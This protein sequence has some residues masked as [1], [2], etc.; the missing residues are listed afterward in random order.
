MDF[1]SGLASFTDTPQQKLVNECTSDLLI[2]MDLKISL[3]I[4]DNI[5]IAPDGG[6]EYLKAI[7]KR[8]MHKSQKVSL[9]AL[10]LLETC[11]KNCHEQFHAQVANREFLNSLLKLSSATEFVAVKEKVLEL[12]ASWAKA[13]AHGGRLGLFAT[14]Y[15]ELTQKGVRFPAELPNQAPVLTPQ[16][17]VPLSRTS[18]ETSAQ[19]NAPVTPVRAPSTGSSTAVPPTSTTTETSAVQT[20]AASMPPAALPA[21]DENA[22]FEK[23]KQDLGVV[24]NYI[25]L[26]R[27]M[28]AAA[29]QEESPEEESPAE[30]VQRVTT[31]L[32]QNLTL[33][34]LVNTLMAIRNRLTLIL[35][36]VEKE[37][38]LTLT[39]LM[40]EEVNAALQWH[41]RKEEGKD[42]KPADFVVP[43]V[44][45]P[46]TQETPSS[47]SRPK[48]NGDKDAKQGSD[49]KEKQE[50]PTKKKSAEETKETQTK[51]SQPPPE[52]DPFADLFRDDD[53]GAPLDLS[54]PDPDQPSS[55]SSSSSSS[56][57]PSAVTSSS[58]SPPVPG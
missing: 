12:I 8:I 58:S 20:T 27:E 51:P 11:M 18:R 17:S 35:V 2:E 31:K 36:E 22:Y 44:L 21:Y 34:S 13:F 3:D 50:K 38:M 23:L 56:S 19:Q 55:S 39:F 14:V 49:S 30:K 15:D 25:Q 53:D 26:L 40:M 32:K 54:A 52:N 46:Y 24:V 1:F 5:N 28:L 7:R 33:K 6:K 10:T 37:D 42:W 16:R 43:E 57:P 9:M 47:D 48:E 45:I 29:D 4:C 41:T